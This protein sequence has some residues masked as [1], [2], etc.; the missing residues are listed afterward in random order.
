MKFNKLTL[1]GLALLFILSVTSCNKDEEPAIQTPETSTLGMN[2][3]NLPALGDDYAYE[4][5]IIVDGAPNTTGIFNVDANGNLDKTSFQIDVD[6][7][8]RATTYALTI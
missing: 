7:L 6:K 2:F 4:G 3:T 1:A 8:A 5:W